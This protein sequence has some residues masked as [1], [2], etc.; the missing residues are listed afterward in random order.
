MQ[1]AP[2][3]AAIWRYPVKSLQGEQLSEAVV[4]DDGLRGDRWWGV[5][6]ETT[7]RILTGRREPRLL[8]A[9]AIV[10]D[11]DE[12]QI[13][14]PNGDRCRGIGPDTDARLSGWLG[15]PV[16]LTD[17]R[18]APGASAEFFADATDDASQAVEWTMPP[19]R[20][21]DAMPLLVLTTASLRAALELHPDGNW[22]VRRFRPNLLVDIFADGWVEDL[23]CGSTVR[24]GAVDLVPRQPC[25]RCTMVT[26]PQPGLERDVD[27]Y[28]TLARNHGGTLGVWSQVRKP[29]TL[30]VGEPTVVAEPL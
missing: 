17:A 8:L 6:D 2:R 20:F 11:D 25:V 10:T 27:I 4:D 24:V 16:T 22:D 18:G 26:R 13:T 19:G 28:K 30:H 23:W 21:V 3:L 1:S 29:G 9:S 12:P 14:L 7:G 5:R 15:R